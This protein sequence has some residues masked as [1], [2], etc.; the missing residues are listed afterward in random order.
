MTDPTLFTPGPLTTSDAVKRCMAHDVGSRT[1]EFAALVRS[2]RAS[3]LELAGV[4]DAGYEVIL[5]QGS[6]TFGIE[7]VLGS[8]TP[9]HGC[10]L[11][12]SNGVYGERIHEINRALGIASRLLE[13]PLERPADPGLVASVLD[14]DAGLTHVAVVHCETTT[15]LLNPAEAIARAARDRGRRCLVDAMSSFGG[16]PLHLRDTGIDYLVS[17][18][19][20]ALESV[21]GFCFVIARRRALHEVR[22]RARSLSLDL[23]A[24]WR[25]LEAT[26]QFRFT[27]PVQALLAFQQALR[28]LAEE[29][30][31]AQRAARYK[32]NCRALMEGM[33]ALGIEPLLEEPVRGYLIN[34]FREPAHREFDFDRFYDLLSER[35]C[36]IYR[37]NVR[38]VR[39]F[40]IATM[41]RIDVTDVRRLLAAIREALDELGVSAP[42]P[43]AEGPRPGA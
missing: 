40:R 12:V 23:I 31:V 43:S 20:K 1:P 25:A 16:V 2:I 15:G 37:G 39:C 32:A 29:G 6:G 35:G 42:T 22:S 8:V 27:P 14:G 13:L 24:Q 21:A 28:E 41:G 9:E 33:A 4:S 3:L 10:W 18:P 5:L 7:S 38:G 26:G 11:V 34:A 17:S 36:V 30:G 19:A